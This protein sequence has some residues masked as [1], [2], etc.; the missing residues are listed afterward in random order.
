MD[1]KSSLNQDELPRTCSDYLTSLHATV[2]QAAQFTKATVD[3]N[4]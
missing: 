4:P 2:E 1:Q 3:H